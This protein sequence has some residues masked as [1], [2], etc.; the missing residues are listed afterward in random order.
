[1]QHAQSI[2]EIQI[3]ETDRDLEACVLQYGPWMHTSMRH[4]HRKSVGGD[5]PGGSSVST[6]LPH[7]ALS[8]CVFSHSA[9]RTLRP[10]E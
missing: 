2:G 8:C 9:G 1:M 10:T 6:T 4:A 7:Y 5:L 3:P